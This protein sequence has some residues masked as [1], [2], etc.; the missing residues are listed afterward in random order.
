MYV[1]TDGQK[2][3]KIPPWKAV[4]QLLP[5]WQVQCLLLTFSVMEPALKKKFL[6]PQS[7]NRMGAYVFLT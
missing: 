6:G 4:L 2:E 3:L 7:P 1:A 5:V